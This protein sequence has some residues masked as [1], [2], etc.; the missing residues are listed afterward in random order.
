MVADGMETVDRVTVADGY[1][2]LA[3]WR[4]QI[5]LQRGRD[6]PDRWL[7]GRQLWFS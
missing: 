4:H 2:F 3:K 1:G 7:D 6:A 5:D